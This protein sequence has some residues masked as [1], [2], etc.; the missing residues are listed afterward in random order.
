MAPSVQ[1][2]DLVTAEAYILQQTN[3]ERAKVGAKALTLDSTLTS[4]ARGR[5]DD[6]ATRNYFSHYTPEGQNVFDMLAAL[7][8]SYRTAGE[9]IAMNT[10]PVSQSPQ[11]IMTAWMSDQGHKDNILNVNYGRI[12]IGAWMRA[13]DGAIYYTQDFS[14]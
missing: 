9:N 10:Y 4:L 8:Y 7:G 12:G 14:N 11:Q 13:S 6:M 2:S 1:S 3:A 5:S